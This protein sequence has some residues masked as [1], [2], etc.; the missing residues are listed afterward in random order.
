M[1]KG[2]VY[3]ISIILFLGVLLALIGFTNNITSSPLST[4]LVTMNDFLSDFEADAQRAVFIAGF[5]SFIALEQ[6]IAM[7]GEF[8][9]DVSEP[10]IEAFINGTINGEFQPLL[11]DATFGEYLERVQQQARQSGMIFDA[12]LQEASLRHTSPWEIMVTYTLNIELE[13]VSQT[14]R[15]NYDET[16]S[17]PINIFDLQDPL[18]S[19]GTENKAP[20]TIRLFTQQNFVHQTTNDTTILQL[21]LN[22]SSYR[23]ST[24]APSFLQRFEGNTSA[25]EYG[26]QSLVDLERLSA[27]GIPVFT[28]RSLVDYLYFFTPN[29]ANWCNIQNMPEFFK[30]DDTNRIFYQLE[31][32]EASPC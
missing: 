27:Q 17:A 15:W 20:N 23:P 13:D 1:R 24:N 22:E 3:T 28:D 32:L 10:F 7:S 8:F 26:I 4:R 25:H 2:Y 5:R 19:V 29:S 31:N 18:Y 9:S 6:E 14:I 30:I 11:V 21:H 12:T 16:F